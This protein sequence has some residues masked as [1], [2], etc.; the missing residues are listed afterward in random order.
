VLLAA[1]H[2]NLLVKQ[3]RHI[4]IPKI[5]SLKL[6]RPDSPSESPSSGSSTVRAFLAFQLHADFP[7]AKSASRLKK[8]R[9]PTGSL[10]EI[11]GQP[12]LKRS[13]SAGPL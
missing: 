1:Q 6:R 9:F 10:V 2:F 11:F 13:K 7:S 5:S 3:I 12:A 4:R 8:L